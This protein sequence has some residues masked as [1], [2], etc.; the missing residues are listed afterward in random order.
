MNYNHVLVAF[1]AII[2]ISLAFNNLILF[3]VAAAGLSFILVR[4]TSKKFDWRKLAKK[5]YKLYLFQK[6]N[7]P[8][9]KKPSA[10]IIPLSINLPIFISRP[11][12]DISIFQKL[13]KKLGSQI[14]GEIRMSGKPANSLNMIKK[15]MS[16]SVLFILVTLPVA[17]I[18][19]IFLTPLFCPR[20]TTNRN[21]VLSKD[22]TQTCQI[23]T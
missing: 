10:R 8:N 3:A 11:I 20:Y 19:G 17:I 23:K 1:V 21:H 5:F 22:I 9:T 16:F 13:Q 7:V 14:E 6:S 2:W 15:S 18:L 12:L 4:H